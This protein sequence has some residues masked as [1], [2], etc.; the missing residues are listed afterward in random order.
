[1]LA[2]RKATQFAARRFGLTARVITE[3]YA[4]RNGLDTTKGVLVTGLV[5]G[6]PGRSS[7]LRQGD[8]ILKIGK[9]EISNLAEFKRLYQE[10][11]E[12]KTK[13]VLLSVQRGNARMLRALSPSTKDEEE[14]E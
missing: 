5:P 13:T 1:M 4:R 12:A 11:I 8:I 14:D 9:R 6:G 2:A 3:I 10:L 7:G